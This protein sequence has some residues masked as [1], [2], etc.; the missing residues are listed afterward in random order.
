M[1]QKRLKN[2]GLDV[3]LLQRIFWLLGNE[4]DFSSSSFFLMSPLFFSVLISK[5]DRPE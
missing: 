5:Y 2:T 4:S 3:K 1:A